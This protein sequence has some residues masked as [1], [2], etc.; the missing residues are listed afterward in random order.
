MHACLLDRDMNRTSIRAD[1]SGLFTQ[2]IV[3]YRLTATKEAVI[4]R[5]C[6]DGCPGPHTLSALRLFRICVYYVA[7]L[8]SYEGCYKDVKMQGQRRVTQKSRVDFK[9]TSP[10]V[11]H[12]ND[13]GRGSLCVRVERKELEIM[14]GRHGSRGGRIPGILQNI[15]PCCFP[16]RHILF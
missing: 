2:T 7:C 6:P 13:M 5:T 9:D 10:K 4:D 1:L 12:Y 15:A 11:G 3:V 8:S 14:F 16:K